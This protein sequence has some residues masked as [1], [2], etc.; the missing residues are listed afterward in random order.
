MRPPI[1]LASGMNIY[2]DLKKSILS[3]ELVPGQFLSENEIAGKYNV[4]R[5]PVK[6]AFLRLMSEGYIEIYPQRG[7]YVTLLDLDRIKEIIFMRTVL[8][9]EVIMSVTGD[10]THEVHE[11]IKEN[12]AFQEK[13]VK[14]ANIVPQDFYDLDSAFHGILFNFAGRPKLWDIIQEFQI[15]Y[16]RFRML[17]IVAT[18][19]FDKLFF[20]HIELYGAIKRDDRQKLAELLYTHLHGNLERLAPRLKGELKDYFLAV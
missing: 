6:S 8:E 9:T 3:L 20:E 14:S 17:D 19:S 5:T 10:L 12:L 7:T 15:Y 4:S 11:K 16:T 2:E 1:N 13:L 18:K